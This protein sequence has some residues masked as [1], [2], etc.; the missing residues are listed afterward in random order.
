MSEI[1]W[2]PS[3]A[4]VEATQ[5][6]KF[7]KAIEKK[8]NLKF[9][10]FL[11]F[12]HW[13]I[14]SNH[15]FWKELITFFDLKIEGDLSIANEDDGF[16]KYGW[17][18]QAR[19]N[20]AENLLLKGKD[21]SIALNFLHESGKDLDV[22][23]G[24]LKNRVLNFQN[25]LADSF[26]EGDVLACY[27]PNIPAT[28]E[29][30]L[31]ATSLG[32]VFT[33]TSSDFGI[34]GVLD[35]FGQSKPKVLVAAIAYTYNNK[36]FDQTEKIK[37]IIKN[38]EG[39]EKIILVDFLGDANLDHGIEGA[40]WLHDIYSHKPEKKELSFQQVDFQSPLY[41]MYSSGTTGKPKCIVHS[42]GGTLLQHVKELGLHSDLNES[43]RIF[44]FTT[45]G[46]MMWNWLVSSL[47]F[48]STIGLYEGSPGLPTLEGFFHRIL[49]KGY[50]IFGTSPKFLRAL[51]DSGYEGNLPSENKLETILSTGAPLLPEQ[52]D[53]VYDK[54]KRDVQLSSI[55]GGT[56]IIGCFMLGNPILPVNR[57]EIQSLGL[58]MDVS[59]FDEQGSE[60]FDR[61]GE[62][63][64]RKSFPSRPLCFLNDKNNE[65]INHAY[66]NKYPN[67]WTHGDF[68]TL[69]ERKSVKVFGRSDATLN[70]GG[71]RIGTAE[72]YRQTETLKYLIDSI[73][74]GRQID[75]DVE[76]VLFVQMNEGE[77]LN[78][79]RVTEI[80]TKIKSGT[81]PRHVPK[82]VKQVSGIPYTRSGK[83]MELA[84]TRIINGKELSNIE[85]VSNPEVLEQYQSILV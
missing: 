72:I 73:C 16:E 21:D 23:Y 82:I 35:R 6:F 25:Y 8:L 39:L 53:F 7:Q 47:A 74:V 52:F 79:E 48:G 66:F 68:I 12:H 60:V 42:V 17:F 2:R 76:V 58:G 18:P 13:S 80:K 19:L 26:G 38:I 81:T 46:W 85:A 3:E 10:N 41:I 36:R 37:E 59:C 64:C 55:C 77:E 30:M 22:T 84:I 65:R 44:Y 83:K 50:H 43:K 49:A 51:E 14:E 33:S 75:G 5:M 34:E 61:E 4:R 45:C 1:L 71:V 63:V 54:I 24:E 20:F 32:G 28:V 57:G 69:T 78:D 29:S 62:L 70:P 11:D 31:A 27:M 56:D 9:S 15:I 40:V 67:V